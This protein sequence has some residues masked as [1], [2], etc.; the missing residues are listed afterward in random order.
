MIAKYEGQ[1]ISVYFYTFA[2]LLFLVQVIV[3]II[4]AGQFLDPDFFFL[5][6]NT[7]RTLHINAMVVW[8]LCGL[9]GATYYVL[10]DESQTELWN[11]GLAKF[12]F[13]A[14]VI[15]ILLVV[16]IYMDGAQSIS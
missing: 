12:Q 16:I 14:T 5:N 6:F 9:M 10:T 2:V 11:V 8:L 13:W 1:K 7:I 3:G 4:A 15:T